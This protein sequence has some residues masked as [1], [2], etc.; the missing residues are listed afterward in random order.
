MRALLSIV[1][2]SLCCV[3]FS[4]T[5]LLS[6][7]FSPAFIKGSQLTI[8][9]GYAGYTMLLLGDLVN[10]KVSIQE[11]TLSKIIGFIPDYFIGRKQEDSINRAKQLEAEIKA[12]QRGA[13]I[14]FGVGLDGITIEGAF[15]NQQSNWTFQFWSPRKGSVDY[16]F[17]MLLFDLMRGSFVR[18]ET[19]K[20]LAGLE[21]YF[22]K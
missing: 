19:Q 7:K 12:L 16:K 13:R 11:A 5:D 2:L 9:K 3:A 17:S 14:E 10:E 15:R 6:V 8:T 21:E 22:P 20:Y 1:L 18:P 4:Q